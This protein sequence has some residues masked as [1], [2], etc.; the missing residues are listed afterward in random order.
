MLKSLPRDCADGSLR[1][2]D[3]KIFWFGRSNDCS[4]ASV[5]CG[6][7]PVAAVGVNGNKLLQSGASNMTMGVHSSREHPARLAELG[8]NKRQQATVWSPKS[9]SD[10]LQLLHASRMTAA[11]QTADMLAKARL[12]PSGH[13]D[14]RL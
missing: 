4:D 1:V 7:K 9:K 5:A 8:A 10:E 12:V 13:F 2:S 14:L 3:T 11:N 6:S